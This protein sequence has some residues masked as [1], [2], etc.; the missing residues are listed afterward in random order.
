M[1]VYVYVYG[2]IRNWVPFWFSFFFFKFYIPHCISETNK[3]EQEQQIP[4]TV[5]EMPVTA[6][7]RL[8]RDGNCILQ[9]IKRNFWSFHMHSVIWQHG[10]IGEIL[11]LVLKDCKIMPCDVEN[12]SS[13]ESCINELILLNF[14]KPAI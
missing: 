7:S 1:K 10:R 2:I 9:A 3:Q 8:S 12:G 13:F 4:F 11:I 14:I 5:R 6:P